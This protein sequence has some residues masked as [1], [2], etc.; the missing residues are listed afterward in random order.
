MRSLVPGFGLILGVTGPF[1]TIA[2][3]RWYSRLLPTFTLGSRKRRARACRRPLAVVGGPARRGR[4]SAGR[5]RTPSFYRPLGARPSGG[6]IA[7]HDLHLLAWIDD[8]PAINLITARLDGP[9]S[10]SIEL[11]PLRAR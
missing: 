1:P 11:V 2:F 5:H 8:R 4:L 7:A 10:R 3:R 6:I 9:S